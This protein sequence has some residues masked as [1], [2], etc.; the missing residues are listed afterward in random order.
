MYGGGTPPPYEMWYE[1]E[2][3][4]GYKIYI[5]NKGTITN[6]QADKQKERQLGSQTIR[7]NLT[8]IQT[9]IPTDKQTD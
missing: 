6:T 8:I 3:V 1:K 4:Q 7:Q 5:E 2:L 9:N